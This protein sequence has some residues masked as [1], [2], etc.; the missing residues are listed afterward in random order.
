MTKRIKLGANAF[1]MHPIMLTNMN[2]RKVYFLPHLK[3]MESNFIG[4]EKNLRKVP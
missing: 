3:K 2:A 1:A 4:I